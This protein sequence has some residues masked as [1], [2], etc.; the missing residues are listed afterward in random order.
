MLSI[1]TIL[2]I[3]HPEPL[4]FILGKCIG[5]GNQGIVYED[6]N[7]TTKVIKLSLI[8]DDFGKVSLDDRFALLEKIYKHII[9]NPHTSVVKVY[10]FD[11]IYIGSQPIFE[12]EQKYI[13]Y[14][15][16]MEKLNSLSEN[17]EKV[18]K[19][20]C[21]AFNKDLKI[22]RSIEDILKEIKE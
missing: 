9:D 6:L 10:N 13:V 4:P 17:E 1:P 7:D 8:Y 19:T 22:D 21:D 15:S 2:Q 18:F 20:I 16:S 14:Y 12:W 11:K 5:Q 3:Y